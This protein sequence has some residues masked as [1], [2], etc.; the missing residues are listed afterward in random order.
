[1]SFPDYYEILGQSG[2]LL[3]LS[4]LPT[5]S[6]SSWTVSIDVVASMRTMMDLSYSIFSLLGMYERMDS[7]KGGGLEGDEKGRGDFATSTLRLRALR[8]R[9]T[10]ATA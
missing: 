4:N 10:R 6:L 3:L 5:C 1:M 8:E 9:R 7:A 2:R